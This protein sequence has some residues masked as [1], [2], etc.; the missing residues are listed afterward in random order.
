MN[1]RSMRTLAG[2]SQFPTTRWTLV[3]A[4]SDPHRKE[5]R[6]A[7][8]FLCENYWYPYMP[9]CADAGIRQFRRR[10]SRKSFSSGCWKAVIS[11]A[12]TR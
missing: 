11:I 8:V 5:A 1:D 4:A 7:L 9:I 2:P 12:P 3:V 6:S 10:I